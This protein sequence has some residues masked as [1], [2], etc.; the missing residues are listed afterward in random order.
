[1]VAETSL[2][3][4]YFNHPG[5]PTPMV[6]NIGYAGYSVVNNLQQTEKARWGTRL[7]TIMKP[8]VKTQLQGEIDWMGS[9]EKFTGELTDDAVDWLKR[10]E[11]IATGNIWDNARKTVIIGSFLEGTAALWFSG[12]TALQHV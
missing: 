6:Q 7:N 4:P 10:F 3:P 11:D 12:L 9:I 5:I 2:P 8:L 1:M